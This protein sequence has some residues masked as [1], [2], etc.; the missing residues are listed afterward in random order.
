MTKKSPLL[1]SAYCKFLKLA[2]AVESL[3]GVDLLDP[4][5][6]ALFDQIVLA[7]NQRQPLTVNQAITLSALGSQSTLHKRVMKLRELDFVEFV[8]DPN[9]QRVKHLAPTEK[10]RKC[11]EK[12]NQAILKSFQTSS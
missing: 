8:I 3:P 5:D 1:S 6:R 4:N 9:D 11:L 10:G 2:A 7:W 12:L